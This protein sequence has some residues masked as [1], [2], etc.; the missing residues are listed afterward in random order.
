MLGEKDAEPA[1]EADPASEIDS[2]VKKSSFHI[3]NN[4]EKISNSS[5]PIQN[6]KLQI[7]EEQK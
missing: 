1:G 7:K 6:E 5:T 3:E 2:K 4:E